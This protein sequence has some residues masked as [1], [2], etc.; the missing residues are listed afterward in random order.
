MKAYD[1]FH[2]MIYHEIYVY[3]IYEMNTTN[4]NTGSQLTL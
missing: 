1:I 3:C 4:L 2:D